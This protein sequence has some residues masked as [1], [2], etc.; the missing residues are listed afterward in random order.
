MKKWNAIEKIYLKVFFACLFVFVNILFLAPS[1]A[2]ASTIKAPIINLGLVSHWTLDGG[3][4][5][6]TSS[7]AGTAT[8]ASGN[9]NTGNLTSM[10]QSTSPARGVIGQA[11]YFDGVADEITTTTSYGNSSSL[12][13]V[14]ISLWF[15]TTVASGKT[16]T[17]LQNL[18]TGV[19]NAWTAEIFV[20]TWGQVVFYSYDGSTIYATSLAATY[21]DGN[22]HHAVGVQTN[23]SNIKLYV[24]GVLQQTTG[25]GTS[26]TSYTNSYWRIGSGKNQ[27]LTHGATGFYTGYID[28]IRIFNRAITQAEITRLYN[29]GTPTHVSKTQSVGSLFSGLV[30][31]WTFDGKHTVWTSATEGTVTDASGNGNTGTITNATQ[32]GFPTRGVIGQAG[33]FDGS[34]YVNLGDLSAMEGQGALGVSFWAKH[35]VEDANTLNADYFL[36]KSGA[37]ADTVEFY[38]GQDD[39]IGFC[40]V[41][42]GG[43]SCGGANTAT[44]LSDQTMV[45]AKSWHHYVGVYDGASVFLY[46]DGVSADSTPPA[47]T[48]NTQD[49][50]HNLQINRSDGGLG[51]NGKI[52]DV[53]IYN[54]ALTQAEIT[55]LYNMGRPT[56]LSATLS[57]VLNNFPS[58]KVAYSL[59]K[60][61][62]QYSGYAM[63]VRRSASYTMY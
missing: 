45:T 19:S 51:W 41:V 48:G 62:S 11:M 32:S 2:E 39:K 20:D 31:H 54:R 42:V 10:V 38:W 17:G 58:A 16:I 7:T 47:L 24:D 36:M 18:Q 44:A 15:N 57:P 13:D 33:N 55:R 56:T 22:W 14:T 53:R 49:S 37:G 43:T 61:S 8:D 9:S 27:F 3:D 21:A 5:N 50:V 6:W 46:I 1:P 52:D 59:L 34:D 40:V 29:I 26:Y 60:P 25:F 63:I 4:T 30:G 12:A 28:D 35:D 23:N